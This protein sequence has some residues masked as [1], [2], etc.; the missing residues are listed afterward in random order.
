MLET[1]R[2]LC[3]S[4]NVAAVYV[5]H[6]LA[7]V[8]ELA[9]TVAV[10]YAGRIV[11]RGPRDAIFAKPPPPVH[12]QAAA[13][14]ARHGGQARRGRHRRPRPAARQPAHRLLLR[15]AMRSGHRPLP[16][17]RSRRPSSSTA[18]IWCTATAPRRRRPSCPPP[19]RPRR[20]RRPATSCCR[21]CTSTASYGSAH[22]LHDI[23]LEVRR[24]E[25]VAVVGESGSGKTTLAR[26]ISGLHSDYTGDVRLG[27]RPPGRERPPA[28]LRRPA[29]RS[30]TC[31][32][33]PTRR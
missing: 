5:S 16:A 24:N 8:A 33:T 2:D 4:H 20:R 6:D 3:H 19:G 32:R 7:V 25:C 21:W 31:S 28:Q 22:V 30:S 15:A 11:E 18:G 23:D 12:P 27:C 26:C 9:D 10:M 29:S 14:G 13:R 17:R 1:V